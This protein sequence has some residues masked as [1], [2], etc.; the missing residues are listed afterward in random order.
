MTYVQTENVSCCVSE[1][2]PVVAEVL[3]GQQLRQESACPARI[4]KLA[5][6]V[7][8]LHHK[9][10]SAIE[11]RE[12][13][14]NLF[15]DLKATAEM[16]QENY[17]P[18][19]LSALFDSPEISAIS[20]TLPK[21][22]A[23]LE[24]ELEKVEGLKQLHRLEQQGPDGLEN[25]ILYD[26]YKNLVRKEWLLYQSL[27]S[28]ESLREMKFLFAGCGGMPMTAIGM[29]KTM[30]VQVDCYDIDFEACQLAHSLVQKL[31]MQNKMSVFHGDA[32]DIDY[33][34]YDIVVVANLA[35]PQ[36]KILSRIAAHDNIKALIVRRVN[37]PV[38]LMYS[39]FDP[40]SLSEIGLELVTTADP[41]D[42]KSVHQ[43]VLLR[44]A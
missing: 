43:S 13:F 34:R 44:R 8:K 3:T 26:K 22:V 2:F 15:A 7:C 35:Q 32:L 39:S 4:Q 11:Q 41:N 21:L 33:T 5:E 24:T 18:E 17:T 40:D 20:V 36:M 30:G 31:G 42:K 12:I 9:A 19:E 10:A 28:D 37:G 25:F 14:D 27:Y 29:A 38:S 1:G 16:L 23:K 6:Q